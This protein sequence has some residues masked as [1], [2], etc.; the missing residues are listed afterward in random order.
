MTDID[1][2]AIRAALPQWWVQEDGTIDSTVLALCDALDAARS[3]NDRLRA[4]ETEAAEARVGAA[5]A[6]KAI[7]IRRLVSR[8]ASASHEE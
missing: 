8:T 7:A 3:D 1:T 6:R 5:E 4:A 2:A